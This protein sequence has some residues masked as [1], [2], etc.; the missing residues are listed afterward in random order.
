MISIV[1]CCHTLTLCA[2]AA[3]AFRS[4]QQQGFVLVGSYPLLVT[5][6]S[7]F[8]LDLSE[9]EVLILQ[10]RLDRLNELQDECWMVG[11]HMIPCVRYSPFLF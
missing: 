3:R 6:T 2:H 8:F 9:Q 11:L 10:Q 4:Q 1:S 7:V 5:G